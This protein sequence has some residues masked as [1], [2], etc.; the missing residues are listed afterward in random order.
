MCLYHALYKF[1]TRRFAWVLSDDKIGFTCFSPCCTARLAILTRGRKSTTMEDLNRDVGLS[2]SHFDTVRDLG[3][4][5]VSGHSQY[6]LVVWG[7]LR[8]VQ[9][10]LLTPLYSPQTPPGRSTFL[11]NQLCWNR[12]CAACQPCTAD[13]EEACHSVAK[14]KNCVEWLDEEKNET[15]ALCKGVAA[16]DDL[17]LMHETDRLIVLRIWSLVFISK[18][19]AW[20]KTYRDTSGVNL[21]LWV[22][23]H[24]NYHFSHHSTC[25]TICL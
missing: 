19:C 18:K 25:E 6:G 1:K 9:F 4:D 10:P 21:L 17:S 12:C 23:H 8:A 16:V 22:A 5:L 14:I 7:F 11:P 3:S 24:S 15:M 2:T 13:L 20:N